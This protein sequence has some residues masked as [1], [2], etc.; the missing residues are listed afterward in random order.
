MALFPR[1]HDKLAA[2]L[3]TAVFRLEVAIEGERADLEGA[4][5]EGY[6]VAGADALGNPVLVDRQAV[7]N[8]FGAK[9]N[10][11]EIVLKHFDPRRLERVS[12]GRDRKWPWSRTLILRNGRRRFHEQHADTCED[13]R[14]SDDVRQPRAHRHD[15]TTNRAAGWSVKTVSAQQAGSAKLR[16]T[17]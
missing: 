8:I 5:F 2:H 15:C 12:F 14:D 10:R 17:F 7:R 6:R 1:L 16:P 9:L 4:E 3:A 13:H 11:D